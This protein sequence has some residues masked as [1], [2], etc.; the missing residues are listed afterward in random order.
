[1]ENKRIVFVAPGKAVLEKCDTLEPKRGEVRVCLAAS[2][3]SSGTE[4]ANLLGNLNVSTVAKRDKPNFPCCLGYST[5]GVVEAVGEGVADF[6]I[7]DR[8]AMTWTNNTQHLCKNVENVHHLPDEIS[9]EEASMLHIACFPLAAIRK[10]HLQIG[11][12]ALVMGLGIL[13]LFAVKLLRAAG[14]APII[15]VDPVPEKR[16]KALACGADY[17]LNPYEPDFAETVHRITGGGVNVAIE[18]TG[19][20]AGL[21]GALDCMAKMGRVALLGCTRD[22]NFTIDYYRKV[23][24]RGVS[25]IGAHTMARPSH[26]SS[27]GLWTLRDDMASLIRLILCGRL[28]LRSMIDEIHSPDEAPAVYARLAVEKAFPIVVFDWRK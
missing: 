11:E 20:G 22:S 27:E 13:G 23:H 16:E 26:E 18:V 6:K 7:G 9:F 25:L 19:V 17:A 12:S 14:A 5:A 10:C 8:V 21:D 1:M 24:G 2:T 4:R 15:A 3:V 28:D